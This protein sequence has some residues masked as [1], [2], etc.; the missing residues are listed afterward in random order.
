MAD[1]APP[2]AVDSLRLFATPVHVFRLPEL[3]GI[4]AELCQRLLAESLVDEGVERSNAG[5][6]HSVPDLA[7]RPEPVYRT[8]MQ[9]IVGCV[10]RA[11]D[12]LTR[13]VGLPGVP[14]L[15]YGLTAWAMVMRDGDYTILHDH[16]DSHFSLAYYADAG[17]A[18]EL[19]HPRS[20]LL[21]FVD[22]R[23][24]SLPIAGI[25]L[26]PSTMTV[27]PRTSELVLFPG[28]LQHYVH[29]YRGRRPRVC[30]SCN[31]NIGQR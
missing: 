1:T 13:E 14:P 28:Y 31:I 18:D 30:V 15:R 3:D 8:L 5:G 12:E 6:W 29:A 23:R 11:L 7:R 17:D 2:D 20:G 10:D 25:E 9:A 22:P 19:A 26:H 21:A 27:R 4:N 16:G 24:S